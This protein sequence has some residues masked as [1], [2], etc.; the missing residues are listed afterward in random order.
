MNFLGFRE[1][2][3]TAVPS[4]LIVP[5]LGCVLALIAGWFIVS[6]DNPLTATLIIAAA[7]SFVTAI[8]NPKAGLYLLTFMAGYLDLMKR[9]GIVAGDVSY[10]DVVFT[11]AVAPILSVCI[12]AAVVLQQ[13]FQRKPLQRWQWQ[14]F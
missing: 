9:L 10:K 4:R 1:T 3:L 2:L 5:A 8:L 7:A 11:L 12:C 13:V 6:Y 14:L